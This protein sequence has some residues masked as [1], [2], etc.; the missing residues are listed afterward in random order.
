MDKRNYYFCYSP[1][2]HKFIHNQHDI[3]YICSAI[4]ETTKS[5]FWLYERNDEL[6]KALKNYDET[7]K[8]LK[9]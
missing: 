1:V 7:F 6:D 2:Q 9:K 5:K 3:P 8:F 4:H